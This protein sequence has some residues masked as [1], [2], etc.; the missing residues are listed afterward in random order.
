MKYIWNSYCTAVVDESEEWSS[1]LGRSLKNIRHP[2]SLAELTVRIPLTLIFFRHLPSSCLNWK[3]YCDDHSSLSYVKPITRSCLIRVN[4]SL[5]FFVNH[6]IPWRMAKIGLG[7]SM[8]SVLKFVN[9]MK[10][11]W[12]LIIFGSASVYSRDIYPS[13]NWDPRNPMWVFG[14]WVVAYD[15]RRGFSNLKLN[16]YCQYKHKEKVKFF[17]G[18]ANLFLKEPWQFFLGLNLLMLYSF[19]SGII[20]VMWLLF[21]NS[22]VSR[23]CLFLSFLWTKETVSRISSCGAFLELLQKE[24]LKGKIAFSLELTR[25]LD[26]T[27]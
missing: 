11:L 6:Q 2:T 13:I 12:Y 8:P 25:P 5:V 7:N 4:I 10:T 17:G 18:S 14:F 22:T 1:E 16:D 9:I 23:L 26:V 24:L 15:F 27:L 19:K 20:S 21:P 3:I